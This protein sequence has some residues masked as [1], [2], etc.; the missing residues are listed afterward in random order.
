MKDYPCPCCFEEFDTK[1]EKIKHLH[2]EH[3]YDIL[4]VKEIQNG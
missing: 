4:E 2:D 1:D 3:E